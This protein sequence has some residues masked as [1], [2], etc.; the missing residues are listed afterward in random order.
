MDPLVVRGGVRRW[1][2]RDRGQHLGR[3]VVHRPL[4][5]HRHGPLARGIS[6]GNR[7]LR[8]LSEATLEV[9]DDLMSERVGEW[10][11]RP[12]LDCG[13]HVADFTPLSAADARF[14]IVLRCTMFGCITVDVDPKGGICDVS[15]PA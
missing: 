5:D 3:H 15:R 9:R 6:C 14:G 7:A 2:H 12:S 13:A 1:S 8:H 4:D 11:C 10:E